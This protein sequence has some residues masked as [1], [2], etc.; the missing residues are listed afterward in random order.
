MSRLRV[1]FAALAGLAL[2]GGITGCG[3][4]GGQPMHV[5]AQF[6]DSVGLYIGNNVNV[7][8]IKVGTVTAIHPSGTHVTADL[9]IDPATK[10]PAGVEALTVSPSVVTDRN[11][12]LSPV[13]RGGPV[14]RDGDVIPLER[15]QTPV[16]VDRLFAAA[17]RLSSQLG[18]T[19]GGR[20]A[21][22]AALDATADTFQGN[23]TKL[24]KA[25]KGFAT[26]VG[27]GVDQRD[28]LLDLIRK[29]DGLTQASAHN[30]ALIRSVTG[31]LGAATQLLDQQGSHLVEVLNTADD[32]L[33]RT[34]RLLH[35]IRGP[36]RDNLENLRVT[37]RTMAGRTRELAEAAD[38]LPTTFQNLANLVDP[39]RHM[40]RAHL[41]L[42]RALLD[43]QL[44]GGV[45]ERYKV[46][47]LCAAQAGGNSQEAK[48]GMLMLGG[49]R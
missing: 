37:A 22:N 29:A 27:V 42:D 23:G 38:V 7:L 33:D 12:E 5:T 44:L 39:V 20:S 16:E 35:D 28:Q 31:N 24:N 6:R 41:G 3:V 9:E 32:L 19:P 34:D 46:P 48:L 45:C 10:I 40:A 11:I 13:Y 36:L 26:T 30:D 18:A 4:F 43:T 21:L 25:L 8:G 47:L 2:L 1:G 15:T 17:D 14:L 49:A